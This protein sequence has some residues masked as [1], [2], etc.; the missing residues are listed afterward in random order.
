MVSEQDR[1]N[2]RVNYVNKL[3]KQDP[4]FQEVQDF[5][6]K[7]NWAI[8]VN[9]NLAR[10]LSVIVAMT[11]AKKVVEIG[12][13]VGYSA[14]WIAKNMGIEGTLWTIE[15]DPIRSSL[16]KEF[17]DKSPWKDRV[18]CLTGAADDVLSDIEEEGLFDMVFID[19]DKAGYPGYLDWAEENLRPGGVVVADNIFLGGSLYGLPVRKVSSNKAEKMEI[20]N[21]RLS[22]GDVFTS[23][24][25]PL[26]DGF[27]V[28]VK[29]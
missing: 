15:K 18:I 17:V 26:F 14:L 21:Q 10:L 22:R 27:F 29:K 1:Q 12:T 13:L 23:V 19:A 20:F 6:E 8:Q 7:K 24:C 3:Y 4:I 9:S 16:A 25:L 11:R 28:A 2:E 5:L